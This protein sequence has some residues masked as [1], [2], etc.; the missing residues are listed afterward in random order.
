MVASITKVINVCMVATIVGTM[1]SMVNNVIIYF[2]VTLVIFVTKVTNFI[3][4]FAIVVTT[5]T[6]VRWLLWLRERGSFFSALRTFCILFLPALSI[7]F[8]AFPVV[9]YLFALRSCNC[10]IAFRFLI[11]PISKHQNRF[12]ISCYQSRAM[13][14]GA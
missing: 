14:L 11:K 5:A 6:S 10:V 13:R 9:C 1:I 3:G 8:Y 2:L 7:T 4:I 12:C